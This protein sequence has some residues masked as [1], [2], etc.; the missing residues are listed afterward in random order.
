MYAVDQP[1]ENSSHRME[2]VQEGKCESRSC[3]LIT[4]ALEGMMDED[5]YEDMPELI[6]VED[7][8]EEEGEWSDTEE[9]NLSE[10][11]EEEE[12]EFIDKAKNDNHSHDGTFNGLLVFLLDNH[13][14]EQHL[15]EG[16]INWEEDILIFPSDFNGID[17]DVRHTQF[18]VFTAY[19]QVAQKVHPISGT[20]PENA[21]VRQS[22]PHDPL[23][24][25]PPL[26]PHPPKFIPSGQ[27]TED[28]MKDL[29]VNK[30]NFLWPEEE[31]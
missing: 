16:P 25:L 15:S 3:N 26:T 23:E 17:S 7:S 27:L 31:K 14:S 20:F 28:C 12:E 2:S 29:N 24:S 1:S 6:A 19:K 21:R 10:S 13:Y 9:E 8:D 4:L 11:K 18:H 30:D 5:E 22:F